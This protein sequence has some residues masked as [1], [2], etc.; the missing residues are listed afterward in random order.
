MLLIRC[1][2]Q[3]SGSLFFGFILN[4]TFAWWDLPNVCD[5]FYIFKQEMLVYEPSCPWLCEEKISLRGD[6][7]LPC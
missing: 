3:K 1:V 4:G 6:I 2:L 5:S 7:L